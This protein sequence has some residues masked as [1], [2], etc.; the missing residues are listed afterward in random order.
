MIISKMV[1]VR[2]NSRNINYYRK[3]FENI[4]T[5]EFIDVNIDILNKNSHN[6][7]VIK[8]DD[9]QS[10]HTVEFRTIKGK[11][12]YY[13]R[14]CCAKN[15]LTKKFDENLILHLYVVEKMTILDI[16]K[17]L[18]VNKKQISKILKNRNIKITKKDKCYKK[19]VLTD[20]HKRKISES[21]KK[22][23]GI[24][25]SM[26]SKYKNMANHLRFDVDYLW[27]SKFKDFEKLR[28]LNRA[29]SHDY[30][31]FNTDIY[32][33][34]ILKFY[35]DEKFNKIY[36]KW[37]DNDKNNW[38]IPSLDHIKPRPRPRDNDELDDINN[39]EFLTWFENRTKSNMKLEIWNEMKKDIY[40]YLT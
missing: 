1:K 24:K 19:Y 10:E 23:R 35:F 29:I 34:Y 22:R 33:K 26:M 36:Q 20:E 25:M 15:L 40:F 17:K 18:N 39:L 5:G 3:Y 6:K 4:K 16:Y 28:F 13:C 38:L 7:I 14:E 37:L 2:L 30:Y 21:S 32:K 12:K 8:C 31:K 27:L 9:C 11:E